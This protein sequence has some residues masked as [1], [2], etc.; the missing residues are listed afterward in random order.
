M[1]M[2]L[3]AAALATVSTPAHA[4]E[5]YGPQE[6]E[7]VEI[8]APAPERI[9][10]DDGAEERLAKVRRSAK[11]WEAAYLTLNAIDAI[12]TSLSPCLK[13]KT[14]EEGNPI[15][16]G[17]LGKHPKPLATFALKAAVAGVQFWQF[18]KTLKHNP[19][20]GRAK[21]AGDVLACCAISSPLAGP[22]SCGSPKAAIGETSP[23]DR[24]RRQRRPLARMRERLLSK[25]SDPC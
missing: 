3:M 10:A 20:R 2:I 12:Q 21:L 25:S 18:N 14:C 11:R 13:A 1:R 15:M 19:E 6:P 8:A 5:A 23:R 9:A 24:W 16:R 22:G 7:V 4:G 17:I